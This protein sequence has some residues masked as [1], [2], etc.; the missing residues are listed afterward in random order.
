MRVA[1]T[2]RAP[3]ETT[4]I[5]HSTEVPVE[6]AEGL[7]KL[8]RRSGGPGEP[9]P[10]LARAS[11]GRPGHEGAPGLRDRAEGHRGRVPARLAAG[12]DE[13]EHRAAAGPGDGLEVGARGEHVQDG[14]A[15]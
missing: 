8:F 6:G 2:T 15:S 3:K 12:P 9:Q 13:D 5:Q 10:A 7:P 4:S 1:R 11:E 14:E